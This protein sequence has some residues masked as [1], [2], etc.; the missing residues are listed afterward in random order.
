MKRFA[1][2]ATAALLASPAAFAADKDLCQIN[3]Q[4]I[5]DNMTTNQA[6][7]GEPARSQVEEYTNQAREAQQA[8]DTEKCI[9]LTTQALQRLKGPGSS[10]SGT[11]GSS[12]GTSN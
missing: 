1:M 3:M 8:G 11:A 7:L 9:T 4:E 5:Q 2:L 12:S 10:E 6:T